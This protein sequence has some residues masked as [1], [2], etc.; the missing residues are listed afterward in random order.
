MLLKTRPCGTGAVIPV[1]P[2]EIKRAYQT[3]AGTT[4]IH[5][6]EAKAADAAELVVAGVLDM[7]GHSLAK[8]R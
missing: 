7:A 2:A 8:T 4:H 5:R 3:Q 1:L 6:R